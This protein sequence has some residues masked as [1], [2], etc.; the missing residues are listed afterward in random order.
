MISCIVFASKF[1]NRW[2]G[3]QAHLFPTAVP[4][5]HSWWDTCAVWKPAGVKGSVRW[6]IYTIISGQA[7]RLHI[8]DEWEVGKVSIAIIKYNTEPGQAKMAPSVTLL[9]PSEDMSLYLLSCRYIVWREYSKN[10]QRTF[11]EITPK[12]IEGNWNMLE[13]EKWLTDG[14]LVMCESWELHM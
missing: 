13:I 3:L 6:T 4:V 7:T 8:S 1:C 5:C 11:F 14:K 12:F 9:T 2:Y 10:S